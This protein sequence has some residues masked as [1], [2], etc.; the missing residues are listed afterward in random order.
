MLTTKAFIAYHANNIIDLQVVDKDRTLLKCL[1]G[2]NMCLDELNEPHYF[3]KCS[4][5]KEYGINL[6]NQLPVGS[7]YKKG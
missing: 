1:C 4:C 6:M 7:F 5:G 2:K 3:A